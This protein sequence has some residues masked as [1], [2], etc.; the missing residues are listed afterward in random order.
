MNRPECEVLIGLGQFRPEGQPRRRLLALSSSQCDPEPTSILPLARAA[1]NGCVLCFRNRR[2]DDV[3]FDDPCF[4]EGRRGRKALA[5][6][7]R[8]RAVWRKRELS[9][10]TF[11]AELVSPLPHIA[12]DQVL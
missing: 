5:I 10:N 1:R 7:H 3:G 8:R 11:Q 9:A 12:P 4:A 2:I 6:E